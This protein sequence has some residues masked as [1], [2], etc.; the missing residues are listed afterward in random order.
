MSEK[1][2]A[3]A[4]MVSPMKM[5]MASKNL[6]SVWYGLINYGLGIRYKF[7]LNDN[8]SYLKPLYQELFGINL[9]KFM[10]NMT[11][12]LDFEDQINWKVCK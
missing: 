7:V 4:C 5:A 1:I 6:R 8:L 3:G 10:D 11:G 2:V 9:Q 12:A